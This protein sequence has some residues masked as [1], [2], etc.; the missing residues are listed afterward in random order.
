MSTISV[1]NPKALSDSEFKAIQGSE[2]HATMTKNR[3]II[4]VKNATVNPSEVRAKVR[5][6]IV[7]WLAGNCNSF[8]HVANSTDPIAVYIE[9]DSDVVHFKLA[10]HGIDAPEIDPVTVTVTVQKPRFLPST[11][12]PPTVSPKINADDLW[13]KIMEKTTKD[14]GNK[15]E[16]DFPKQYPFSDIELDK[17]R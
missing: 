12:L 16:L 10:F 5:K 14:P 15:W 2:L 9:G 1:S 6:L 7:E 17:I 3:S 8:Y 11:L 13:K 4:K